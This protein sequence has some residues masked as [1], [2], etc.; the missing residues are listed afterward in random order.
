MRNPLGFLRRRRRDDADFSAEIAA[1]LALEAERLVA[2]GMAPED[3]AWEA[4]RRFGNVTLA[5]E[6]FH[7]RRTIGWLEAIPLHLSRAARRLVRAPAFAITASLTLMLGIGATT[8]VF[9]LV[10]AVL[11]RPLPF[12]RPEQLVDL[13][14]TMVL[15]GLSRVDQSDATYLY[16]RRANHVFT[17]VGAY[18]SA[19]VNLSDGGAAGEPAS[20]R[21]TEA[22]WMSAGVF[23]L[24]GIMPLRGRVFREDEDLPGVPPVVVLGEGLWKTAFTADPG[25]VGRSVVIDGVTRTVVGVMPGRFAFPDGRT[26]LWLPVGID[27]AKTA[28]AAFDFRAVARLRPGLTPEQA[29]ADLEP[30][31]PRVPEAFP[32]RLTAPAIRLTRMRPVVRPLRDTVVGDVGRALWIV[33]GAAA[34]LLLVA[35]ANVANLFLVRAEERQHDLVVRRALGAGRAAVVAQ[36][37][38]EALLLATLGSLLGLLLAGAG[39]GVLRAGAGPAIPRVEEMGLDA[40]VAGVAAGL[41]VL[42]A[43]GLSVV[44]AL[45]ACRVDAAPVLMQSG[46]GATAGRSRHRARRALVVVQVALALVLVTGAGLM[47]RSFRALRAVPAG[48]TPEGAFTFRVALPAAEYPTSFATV[49]LVTRALAGLSAL[50]GVA[51]AGAVSRLPLDAE[52]RRDTAVWVEDR[53]VAMGAMPN[54]H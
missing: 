43:L 25:I 34:F 35:C 38:A 10:D 33:L 46:R 12:A 2:E 31:L 30:L 44:P 32:G 45:R 15:Q 26:A 40:A 27:P 16:Y 6:E 37:L 50:P 14:H 39:L 19:A 20:A 7:R 51:G 11:L 3:A 48:F 9:S 17:D 29:A 8:A 41:T 24:L 23:R 42:I 4:R 21:R 52:A 18:R 22:A 36:F 5:R 1:H 53:P 49:G 47:A 28:S 54:V 13:S